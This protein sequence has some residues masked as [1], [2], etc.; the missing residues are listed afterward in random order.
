M[1][2]YEERVEKLEYHFD[3][4]KGETVKAYQDMAMELTIVKGLSEDSIVR[5]QRLENQ[6]E[7]L[8]LRVGNLEHS[9]NNLGRRF[10]LFE[11]NVNRRFETFE[12]NVNQHFETFEHRL[13][14]HDGRFDRIEAL[15]GQV[16]ERLA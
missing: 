6:V 3:L 1:A 10:D 4:F 2:T 13:G 7:I 16:L 9:F 12:Q 15:L 5:L 11:Q 8:N 14:E